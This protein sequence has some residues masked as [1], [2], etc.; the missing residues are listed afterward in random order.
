LSNE[1][2]DLRNSS[3]TSGSGETFGGTIREAAARRALGLAAAMLMAAGLAGC[4]SISEQTARVIF[5]A[6]AK[7]DDKNCLEIENLITANRSRQKDLEQ[8]MARADQ[9]PSGGFVNAIAY[10]PDYVQVRGDLERLAKAR[11]DKQ[12]VVDSKFSSGRAV[13]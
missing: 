1:G 5:A 4:A 11:E 3:A 12:C 13:F 10:Q 2:F 6:P 8:L 7:F 9:A